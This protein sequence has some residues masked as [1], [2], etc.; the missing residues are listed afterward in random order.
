[1]IIFICVGVIHCT[2]PN[3]L[4]TTYT[5]FLLFDSGFPQGGVTSAKGEEDATEPRHIRNAQLDFLGGI[6]PR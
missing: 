5:H 3:S 4:S 2:H 1:M 6:C